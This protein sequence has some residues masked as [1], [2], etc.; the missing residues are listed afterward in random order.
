V[1]SIIIIKVSSDGSIKQVRQESDFLLDLAN[2][3]GVA[4]RREIIAIRKVAPFRD[5]RREHSDFGQL[6]IAQPADV[7]TTFPHDELGNRPKID[8]SVLH[9]AIGVLRFSRN[10]GVRGC[11]DYVGGKPGH[12][13]QV[14]L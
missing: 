11:F 3:S 8:C 5:P 1:V 12:T 2:P 14:M 6:L 13:F 4:L 7:A 10:T 9:L